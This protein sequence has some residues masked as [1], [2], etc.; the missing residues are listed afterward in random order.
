MR[1][2]VLSKG[3]KAIVDDEDYERASTKRWFASADPRGYIRATRGERIDGKKT[4]LYLS[5]YV[6]EAPP[7]VFVDHING[8]M[9]DN[10]KCNLRCCSASENQQNRHAV[11]SRSGFKGV[12]ESVVR[13]KSYGYRAYIKLNGGQ[14]HIG[15]FKDPESA[16]RAYDNAAVKYFGEFACTNRGLGLCN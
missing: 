4:T 9:L 1:E 2:I 5:R 6:I 15:V 8:D 16:A 12:R 11:W 13:G 3:Y 7:G 14:K 10:R